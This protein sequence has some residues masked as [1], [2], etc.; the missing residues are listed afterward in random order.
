MS[1]RLTMYVFTKKFKTN[2]YPEI[3]RLQRR[4]CRIN[5][6]YSWFATVLNRIIFLVAIQSR[7]QNHHPLFFFKNYFYINLYLLQILS[8]LSW[9]DRSLETRDAHLSGSFRPSKESNSAATRFRLSSAYLNCI[10]IVTIMS[11]KIECL[12]NNTV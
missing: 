7:R 4:L 8:S 10:A 11:N 3:V 5:Q 12:S 6:Y 1:S 2:S 9:Q